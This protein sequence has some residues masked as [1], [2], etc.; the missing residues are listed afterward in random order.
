VDDGSLARRGLDHCP[1]G[2]RVGAEVDDDRKRSRGIDVVK[3][4]DFI[5]DRSNITVCWGWKE[6][7]GH[8]I[9]SK[10]IAK[11]ASQNHEALAAAPSTGV[12]TLTGQGLAEA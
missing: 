5:A 8:M 9:G 1:E 10:L 2:H 3:C 6:H 4:S 12:D 7:G 11:L